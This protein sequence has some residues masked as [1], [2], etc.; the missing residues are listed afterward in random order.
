MYNPKLMSISAAVSFFLSMPVE[1]LTS[2]EHE[3][4]RICTNKIEHIYGVDN[5]TMFGQNAWGITSTRSM[6]M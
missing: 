3:A 5:F 6:V 1:C 4:E 2:E